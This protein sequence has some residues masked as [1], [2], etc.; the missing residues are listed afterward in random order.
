VHLDIIEVYFLPTGAQVKCLKSNFK[1]HIKIDVK[2]ALTCFGAVTPSSGSTL[3]VLAKQVRVM[4]SLMM[5]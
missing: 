2:T 5:V 4:R 3:L 1:I